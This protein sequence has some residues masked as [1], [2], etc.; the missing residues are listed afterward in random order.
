M[1]TSEPIRNQE[2]TSTQNL[3]AKGESM[4]T[5]FFGTT[6]HMNAILTNQCN[7][8]CLCCIAKKT[9]TRLKTRFYLYQMLRKQ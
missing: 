5:T 9:R 4:A 2:A 3:K 1:S 7:R 6:K 8:N